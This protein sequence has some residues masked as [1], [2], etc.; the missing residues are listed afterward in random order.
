MRDVADFVIE[1]ELLTAMSPAIADLV[2]KDQGFQLASVVQ[3]VLEQKLSRLFAV[4]RIQS[5]L[6][7]ISDQ[8]LVELAKGEDWGTW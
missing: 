5:V 7:Q 2:R 3:Q 6:T 4:A 8:K 1:T